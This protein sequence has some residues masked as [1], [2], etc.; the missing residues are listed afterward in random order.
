MSAAPK[1]HVTGT[2]RTR[3]PDATLAAIAPWMP[4]I[5]VTRLANVTGLDR[6]G[7]PVWVAIRPTS[8]SLVTSQGKGL[9]TLSAKV[10]A[11]MESVEAWH[12]EHVDKPVRH[13][14]FASLSGAGALD[15]ARLPGGD[16]IDPTAEIPWIEGVDLSTGGAVLVPFEAVTLSCVLATGQ[17]PAI[18][19]S[20]NGLAS[21]NHLLEATVHGLCEVIERDAVAKWQRAGG[22]AGG[23]GKLDLP[24]IEDP[25][26]AEVIRRIQTAAVG[27]AAFD[28]TSDL[29]IPAY[30]VEV[31]DGGVDPASWRT[32][33]FG[34]YGAHPAPEIAL[35]RALTEAVQSRLT[36]LSGSRDDLFRERY[37]AP[38]AL[39]AGH[40][41]RVEAAPASADFG[42]RRSLST[43]SFE[44]DLKLL[45]DALQRAGIERAVAVDLTREE[46]GI[47]VVKI[48][49]PGLRT[50]LSSAAV[51]DGGKARPS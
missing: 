45:L 34:G 27:V 16:A 21:G 1:A 33:A 15:P 37:S 4:R 13:A 29:G 30:A 47:P 44:G 2:H 18:V 26:C 10:S 7:L 49:A 25:A 20:S 39:L 51:R 5:G 6:I 24:R 9:D 17:R 50:A 19:P 8:R 35:L 41:R 42:A 31:F 23:V 28:I 36:F 3:S 12:A 40:V 38:K 22:S 14:S 48:I 43:P 32:G 46:M 11:L